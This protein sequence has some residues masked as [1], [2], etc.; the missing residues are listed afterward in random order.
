MNIGFQRFTSCK[1]EVGP[2]YERSKTSTP[3]LCR[4]RKCIKEAGTWKQNFTKSDNQR[5]V[6]RS[7]DKISKRDCDKMGCVVYPDG[8]SAWIHWSQRLLHY[9]K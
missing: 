8:S 3:F 2:E 4:Y 6:Q 1:T 7:M 9:Y 5:Q